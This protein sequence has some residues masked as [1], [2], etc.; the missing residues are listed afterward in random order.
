MVR[1][2]LGKLFRLGAGFKVRSVGPG[3][4]LAWLALRS[5]QITPSAGTKRSSGIDQDF[6][7]ST[8]LSTGHY[9][10]IDPRKVWH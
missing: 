10:L 3:A 6:G 5:L 2:V 8:A 4:A 1:W 9:H 7:F